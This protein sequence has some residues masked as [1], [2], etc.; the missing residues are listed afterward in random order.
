MKVVKRDDKTY[1][2]CTNHNCKHREL[3]KDESEQN[4]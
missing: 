2:V 1:Y 3:V 4:Q